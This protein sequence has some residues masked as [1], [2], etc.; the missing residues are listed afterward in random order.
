MMHAKQ[1]PGILKLH[2]KIATDGGCAFADLAVSEL[3]TAAWPSNRDVKRLAGKLVHD[4][5][6][7]TFND[8]RNVDLCFPV[9]EVNVEIDRQK[10][11]FGKLSAQGTKHGKMIA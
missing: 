11:R 10:Q 9:G 1:C 8:A 3:E 7:D 6:A 2:R 5:L 4:R